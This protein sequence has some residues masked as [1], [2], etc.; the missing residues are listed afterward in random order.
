MNWIKR[1]YS[2]KNIVQSRVSRKSTEMRRN[3]QR[4][5]SLTHSSEFRDPRA[6]QRG[7]GH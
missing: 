4:F 6:N 2:S 5:G 3:G 7:I 1:W